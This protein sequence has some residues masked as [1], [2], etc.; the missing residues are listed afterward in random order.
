MTRCY[1]RGGVVEL[2]ASQASVQGPDPKDPQ[3]RAW[4]RRRRRPAR[5]GPAR[6]DAA[7]ATCQGD[8]ARAMCLPVRRGRRGVACRFTIQ[9][10]A[11]PIRSTMGLVA[12]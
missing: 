4:L 6:P 3:L 7:R 2:E 10:F 11:D 8:P 12:A 5:P 9:P 1:E